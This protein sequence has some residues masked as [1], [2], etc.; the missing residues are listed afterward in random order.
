MKQQVFFILVLLA[1][2]TSCSKGNKQGG[3]EATYS[4]T[5]RYATGFT[6]KHY[7]SYREVEVRDPWDSTRILQRYL[8]VDRNKDIPENLPEGTIVRVPLKRL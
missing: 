8:L 4:D 2:F 1:F 7:P 3:G 6:V 5:I